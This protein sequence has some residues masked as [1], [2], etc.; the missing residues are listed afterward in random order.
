MPISPDKKTKIIVGMA[1]CGI[2]AGAAEVYAELER[3]I[4]EEKLPIDLEKT[5]CIGACYREPLMEIRM[6]GFPTVIY[7]DVTLKKIPII[8]DEHI[9]K[10]EILKDWVVIG[11]G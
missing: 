4:T 11:D 10:H 7:G 1:S 2:A 6:E 3:K 5:G 8:F 9:K